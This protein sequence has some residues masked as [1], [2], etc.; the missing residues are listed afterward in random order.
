MEGC[1]GCEHGLLAWSLALRHKR[2]DSTTNQ[3][4]KTIDAGQSHQWAEKTLNVAVNENI[5]LMYKLVEH[6]T[7]LSARVTKL[8]HECQDVVP[9]PSSENTAL[10]VIDVATTDQARRR[11][12]PA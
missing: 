7:H 11:K 8:E 5:E 4:L 2:L 12:T 9:S 6:N 10:R 1:G 3:Q